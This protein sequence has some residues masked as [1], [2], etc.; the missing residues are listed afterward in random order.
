[1]NGTRWSATRS[2][3][4][5]LAF[6]ITACGG[7]SSGPAKAGPPASL[8]AVSG[9]GQ[10]G[11][12]GEVLGAPL[13]VKVADAQGRA[14]EKAVVTFVVA[15]GGGTLSQ[16]TDTTDAEGMASV[17]WTMGG[18]LGDARVEARVTGLVAPTV[19]TATVKAGPPTA[20]AQISAAVGT[21]ASGF[22]VT[23]SV[24]IRVVDRFQHPVAGAQVSFAVTAGGGSV[25]SATRTTGDDGIARTAWRLGS[26]GPQ[27]LRASAGSIS[28]DVQGT[29]VACQEK[30]LAIGDVVSISPASS[31]MCL[32]TNGSGNQK[33]IVAVSNST[34]SP[35]STA[36]F[37]LR[38]AG[39]A[40]SSGSL[41]TTPLAQHTSTLSAERAAEIAE[42]REA[43]RV[44][45][46]LLRAN[47]QLLERLAPARRA[48]IRA[49]R[50]NPSL[51]LQMPPAPAV[52]DMVGVKIPRNFDNLCQVSTAAPIRAR[53]V[54][55][56]S[57]VVILEDSA[58]ITAGQI[59]NR[60]RAIGEE[61]DNVMFPILTTN[62]GDPLAMDAQTDGNGRIF[63]VFSPVVNDLAG[64]NI[65]GFV[66][67]GD[68][69]PAASCPAS[70]VGE[71]FYA[72]APTSDAGGIDSDGST[73]TADE[74]S[75]ATR[76]VIIHEVKHITSFAEKFA[77]PIEL[78]GNFFSRDQ[79][80]EES[81]A[82]LAEE[83]WA[84][85]VFGYGQRANVNYASSIYCEVRP[86]P[87]PGYPQC[88]PMKPL[89][90]LD[91]F[92]FLY[93]FLE[94]PESRSAIGPVADDDFSFYGSGWMFLRWLV[95]NYATSEAAFL[96]ALN[97]EM[98]FPG[99]ENI[100]TRTSRTLGELLSDFALALA[101]DDYPG[102]TPKDAKH[103]IASW[104]TR[105]IFAGLNTDFS[106]QGFFGK[107]A[108]LRIRGASLGRFLIDVSSVTGGGF[109]IFEVS[110]TSSNKQLLEFRGIAGTGFP[111]D[112]QVKIVRVQ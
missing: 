4:I 66:T 48:Q 19:F 105:N 89:S 22:D 110:G 17:R 41:V 3:S 21:S 27:T 58:A 73:L 93:D 107:A 63:M 44:H 65:A 103:S 75:R 111:S 100:E 12:S 71:Y 76:T 35:I 56:G 87:N 45:N 55:A 40:S 88:Q 32:V 106:S 37:R 53:V 11:E 78:P 98:T 52:G 96:N 49:A 97:K 85:G 60:Y 69:F 92:F 81:S 99:T 33:Y 30:T 82:M 14:V 39:G 83:L 101:L 59:D 29:A 18:A 62:F 74:W 112:M 43:V 68:F 79:W 102:F 57:R 8:T 91:H 64:G 50:N 7:D 23:D 38:G 42:S 6:A 80:L 51:S 70:N 13:T 67:S 31:N 25:S 28:V 95:D 84:R 94:N 1:M 61:F 2:A 86:N 47:T 54:Y 26:A 90:M 5:L 108:P 104:N 109:S 72:R 77:S 34:A 16:A 9:S 15:T 24:S 46:R 10:Q 20:A 36:S